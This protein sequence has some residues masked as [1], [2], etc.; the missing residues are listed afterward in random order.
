MLVQGIVAAAFGPLSVQ[1]LLPLG[2]PTALWA[3][4]LLEPCRQL[5]QCL[6]D[7]TFG[8]ATVPSPAPAYS[9]PCNPVSAGPASSFPLAAGRPSAASSR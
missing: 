4:R 7:E 2:H 3:S 9:A 1:Q 6:P 5:H 8:Q